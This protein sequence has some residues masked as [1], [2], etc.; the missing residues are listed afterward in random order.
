MPKS[1]FESHDLSQTLPDKTSS[2]EKYLGVERRRAHRRAS[3]E[4]RTEV[5]FEIH[6]TTRRLNGGRRSGDQ[7]VGYW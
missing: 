4:R 2:G 6:G 3:G 1:H 7:T 5:R